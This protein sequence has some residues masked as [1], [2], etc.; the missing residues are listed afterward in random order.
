MVGDHGAREVP[1]F[2]EEKVDKA[3]PNS[4]IYDNT[5]NSQKFSNDELFVTSGLITYLGENQYLKNLFEP[6]S[7]KVVKT[8]TD[9]HDMIRTLYDIVGAHT[10]KDMPSSRNGRNLIELA[11]NLTT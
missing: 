2:H 6:V 7:G 1:L 4:A 10:G 11:A 8:P 5:C 9:H 3:D